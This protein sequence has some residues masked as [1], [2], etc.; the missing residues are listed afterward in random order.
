[1]LE[2][3]FA[4]GAM[5]SPL[6]AFFNPRG[7]SEGRTE[8]LLGLELVLDLAAGREPGGRESNEDT[9]ISNSVAEERRRGEQGLVVCRSPKTCVLSPSFVFFSFYFPVRLGCVLFKTRCRNRNLLR[10]C[11]TARSIVPIHAAL[12]IMIDPCL[13]DKHC[14]FVGVLV[15]CQVFTIVSPSFFCY[16]YLDLPFC[17]FFF[18][19]AD[20]APDTV[21]TRMSMFVMGASNATACVAQ[22]CLDYLNQ[23]QC[24]IKCSPDQGVLFSDSNGAIDGGKV[25]ICGSVRLLCVFITI[26]IG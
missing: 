12:V 16:S 4:E 8:W 25:K 18:T 2:L 1:M 5:S 22:G 6:L 10:I 26:F 9:F 17:F 3:C 24:A 19:L 11:E 14:L 20:N 23:L 15:G 13:A 7:S 21:E